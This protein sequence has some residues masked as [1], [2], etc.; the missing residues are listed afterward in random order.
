[1]QLPLADIRE[2]TGADA[3]RHARS[4]CPMRKGTCHAIHQ[5]VSFK[6]RPQTRWR[7]FPLT[8]VIPSA[9]RG[10]GNVAG[11]GKC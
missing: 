5:K 11:T 8:R 4:E 1:M 3:R 7:E 2:F 9:I 6:R 10:Q